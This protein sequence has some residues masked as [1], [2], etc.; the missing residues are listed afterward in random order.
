MGGGFHGNVFPCFRSI[1]WR[2]NISKYLDNTKDGLTVIEEGENM[3]EKA[4]K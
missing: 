2:E 4:T 1:L 3:Q